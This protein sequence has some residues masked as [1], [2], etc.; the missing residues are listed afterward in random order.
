MFESMNAKTLTLSLD[1]QF[2]TL[3]TKSI[4]RSISQI[5]QAKF[6][7]IT[8]NIHRNKLTTKTLAQKETQANKKKMIT[9]QKVFLADKGVQKLQQVFNTTIDINSIKEISKT[10]P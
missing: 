9:L 4:Q 1:E 3:L 7:G 2:S 5:L 6:G 10:S 8:L